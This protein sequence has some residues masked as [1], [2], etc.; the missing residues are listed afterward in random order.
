ML[1]PVT[2]SAQQPDLPP[3]HPSRQHLLHIGRVPSSLPLHPS[4]VK[5]GGLCYL[6]NF[7][8]DMFGGLRSNLPGRKEFLLPEYWQGGRV[9]CYA[10]DIWAAA[11]SLYV[12]VKG[13]DPFPI[14]RLDRHMERMSHYSAFPEMEG[15]SA[16]LQSLLQQ[17]LNPRMAMRPTIETILVKIGPIS[18]G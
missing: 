10:A 17:C 6:S 1:F 3:G 14:D 4:E 13:V 2:S 11:V 5:L 16:E 12:L 18:D 9:S 8:N 7:R 15:F